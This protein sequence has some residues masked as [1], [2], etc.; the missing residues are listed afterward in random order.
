MY[1]LGSGSATPETC[2]PED[3]SGECLHA[4]PQT[5]ARAPPGLSHAGPPRP[6]VHSVP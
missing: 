5:A 6:G 3:V 2:M 4:M 1:P